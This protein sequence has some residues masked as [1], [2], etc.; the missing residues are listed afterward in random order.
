MNLAIPMDSAGNAIPIT[1]S[2]ITAQGVTD[3]FLVPAIQ[4]KKRLI[5]TALTSKKLEEHRRS[6]SSVIGILC[7]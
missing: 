3:A 5:E 1:R 6:M 4:T 7:G 2:N